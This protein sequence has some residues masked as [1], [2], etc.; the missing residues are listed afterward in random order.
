MGFFLG[1]SESFDNKV[2]IYPFGVCFISS[3]NDWE[4]HLSINFD[5]FSEEGNKRAAIGAFSFFANLMCPF[6]PFSESVIG[7]VFAHGFKKLDQM[8]FSRSF[9]FEGLDLFFLHDPPP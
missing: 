9:G 4:T 6:M 1:F 3:Q 7:D 2:W 8:I 5:P